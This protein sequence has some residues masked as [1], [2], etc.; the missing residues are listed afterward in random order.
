MIT[1]KSPKNPSKFE[2][3]K[4]AYITSNKKDFNKH[5]TTAKHKKITN[6]NNFIPKNPLNRFL[7][8]YK[9]KYAAKI[10]NQKTQITAFGCKTYFSIFCFRTFL[11]KNE[12]W[13]FLKMSKSAKNSRKFCLKKHTFFDPCI[14]LYRKPPKIDKREHNL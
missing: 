3:I 1:K 10:F 12:N 13:T 2:C 4:C 6:D 14:F 8:K 5:L 7:Q 11:K 9:K